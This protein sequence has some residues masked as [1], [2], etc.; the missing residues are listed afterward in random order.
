M[1]VIPSLTR[2]SS[3]IIAHRWL[4]N[5]ILLVQ[6]VISAT[7]AAKIPP[8]QEILLLDKKLREYDIPNELKQ[9]SGPGNSETRPEL[10]YMKQTIPF[11][12]GITLLLLHKRYLAV[13]SE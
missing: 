7:L 12:T 9:D 2:I 11:Y 10:S 13:V 1:C 8:Y 3:F 5:F 4:I 6:E